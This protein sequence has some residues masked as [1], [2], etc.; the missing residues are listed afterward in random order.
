MCEVPKFGQISAYLPFQL[1]GASPLSLSAPSH[2]Q[3]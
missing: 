2:P 1:Q 3:L